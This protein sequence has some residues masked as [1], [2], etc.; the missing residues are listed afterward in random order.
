MQKK[1]FPLHFCGITLQWQV[2]KLCNGK[3][4]YWLML[5]PASRG[6]HF[7]SPN[8]VSLVSANEA[9]VL[10]AQTNLV[11]T[12][13]PWNNNSKQTSVF[14]S[15]RLFVSTVSA[16]LSLY[17]PLVGWSLRI[18]LLNKGGGASLTRTATPPGGDVC[19]NILHGPGWGG[20]DVCVCVHPQHHKIQTVARGPNLAAVSWQPELLVY[21]CYTAH[22]ALM[23]PIPECSA[24]SRQDRT[25]LLLLFIFII[26]TW[27][28][29]L[30]SLLTF[31]SEG[32]E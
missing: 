1:V 19:L 25:L 5:T 7:K 23:L 14:M 31:K 18:L 17:C 11:S 15:C 2:I 28:K 30:I 22:V 8:W 12:H 24:Q 26:I 13:T 9:A 20:G 4:N 10:S 29:M 6:R 32:C 16:V 3:C 27:K 21:Y